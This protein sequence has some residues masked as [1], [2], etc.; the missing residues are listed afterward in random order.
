MAALERV[1]V[2]TM[3]MLRTGHKRYELR[4]RELSRPDDELLK[5]NELAEAL[6]QRYAHEIDLALHDYPEQWFNFFE[7]WTE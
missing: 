7:F 3:F 5:K 6:L 2:V 4:V 1:P